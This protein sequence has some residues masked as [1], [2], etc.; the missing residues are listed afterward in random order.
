MAQLSPQIEDLLQRMWERRKLDQTYWVR[1]ERSQIAEKMAAQGTVMSGGFVTS[2]A[3]AYG[4]A[5]NSCAKGA[6]QDAVTLVRQTFGNVSPDHAAT[7]K[8]RLTD[9]FDGL[10]R[11][12]QAEV[13]ESG[14]MKREIPEMVRR[15]LERALFEAKRDLA[16]E[17][18]LETL[19]GQH[20]NALRY[21][22]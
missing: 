21:R 19:K 4:Q 5:F 22:P 10:V 20:V 15:V 12:F 14:P 18:D 11:T 6:S 2:V 1:H 7:L 13:G 17:L 8:E 9:Y 3:A 16:I